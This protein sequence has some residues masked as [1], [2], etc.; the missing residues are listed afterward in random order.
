MREISITGGGK[1]ADYLDALEGSRGDATE[2]DPTARGCREWQL[3]TGTE[4]LE[5]GVVGDRNAID[6]DQGAERGKIG[7]VRCAPDQ[8]GWRGTGRYGAQSDLGYAV[9]PGRR[10]R[11]TGHELE[12][13][14]ER[15]GGLIR[16]GRPVYNACGAELSGRAP[17]GVGGHGDFLQLE[18]RPCE[19][20]VDLEP[21]A[22]G[23]R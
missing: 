1:S 12:D 4:R 6:D 9:Q 19:Y 3:A 5:V 20:D 2:I 10:D 22:G 23:N 14:R 7:C 17:A 16:D 18:H 13:S 21:A 15:G 11:H 8:R